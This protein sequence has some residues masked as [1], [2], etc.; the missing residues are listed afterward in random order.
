MIGGFYQ[1]D[2]AFTSYLAMLKLD[3]RYNNPVVMIFTDLLTDHLRLL[4]V[5]RKLRQMRVQEA[6]LNL[7]R[8]RRASVGAPQLASSS[9]APPRASCGRSESVEADRRSSIELR[10]SDRLTS[11]RMSEEHDHADWDC[12]LSLKAEA[13]ETGNVARALWQLS[14]WPA[15]EWRRRRRRQLCNRWQLTRMLLL[16]P[17]WRSLRRDYGGDAKSELEVARAA[18]LA[19]ARRNSLDQARAPSISG[20]VTNLDSQRRSSVPARSRKEPP[21]PMAGRCSGG[22]GVS[23]SRA[24]AGKAAAI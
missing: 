4:R 5:R 2:A 12:G 23:A 22:K 18:A 13:L 6:R 16:H 7:Y 1:F 10:A 14:L 3:H 15:I 11:K 19:T 8:R 17:E 9:G 20:S 24:L 21:L